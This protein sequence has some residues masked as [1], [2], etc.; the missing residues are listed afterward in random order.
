VSF[1]STLALSAGDMNVGFDSDT[2]ASD[3][4]ITS[5]ARSMGCVIAAATDA[6]MTPLPFPDDGLKRARLIPNVGGGP[7]LTAQLRATSQLAT[8]APGNAHPIM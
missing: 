4:W 7:I 8:T 1:T 5:A 3:S 6:V 2:S